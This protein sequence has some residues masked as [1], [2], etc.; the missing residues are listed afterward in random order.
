MSE[1]LEKNIY[2]ILVGTQN[3]FLVAIGSRHRDSMSKTNTG[4][5]WRG[6]L[7]D[8]HLLPGLVYIFLLVPCHNF[9][10]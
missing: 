7:P 6:D 9:F 3:L 10:F 8:V 2:V 5:R 4:Y 1:K